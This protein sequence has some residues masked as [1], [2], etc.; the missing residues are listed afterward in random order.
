MINRLLN[1]II[2]T[3]TLTLVLIISNID[4]FEKFLQ[5]ITFYGVIMIY[6]EIKD[7]KSNET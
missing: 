6:L 2:A 3:I 4:G 5:A 1:T 7:E